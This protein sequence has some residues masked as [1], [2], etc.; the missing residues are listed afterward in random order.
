M[1]GQLNN[2]L[3]FGFVADFRSA[4][5][6]FDVRPDTFDG[7]DDLG[8]LLDVPDVNAKPDDFGIARQEDFRNVERTLVDVELR[9]AGARLQFAEI[10][11]QIAQAERGVDIFRV[12]R[13]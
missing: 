11:Q 6:D 12:E 10:G 1:V 2:F 4:E 9:E 7:G 13:G 3:L 8:G 5:D